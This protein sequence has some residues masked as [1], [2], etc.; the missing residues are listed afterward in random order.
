MNLLKLID[1]KDISK[2]IKNIRSISKKIVFTNGCFDII[3]AGH[4]DYMAKAK[5]LGDVLIVGVNSDSSVKKIKDHGRPIV[6][7]EYRLMVLDAINVIDHLVVFNEETPLELIKLIKPDVLV[8]GAD[9]KDK[10]VVGEDIV[11]AGGGRVELIELLPGISTSI[12]VDKIL[13]SYS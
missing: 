11:R 1:K 7:E 2:K 8:K 9:W 6:K 3:H 4:I 10:G 13:K 12:I 5:A